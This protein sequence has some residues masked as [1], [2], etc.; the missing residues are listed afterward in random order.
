MTRGICTT[1]NR[2]KRSR[3]FDSKTKIKFH[4]R[5]GNTWCTPGIEVW[6]ADRHVL[7]FLRFAWI[8][9]ETNSDLEY[10]F[11]PRYD[12]CETRFVGTHQPVAGAEHPSRIENKTHIYTKRVHISMCERL[13][14]IAYLADTAYHTWSHVFECCFKAQSSKFE[15]LFSLKCGKRNVRASSFELSKMSPQVGLAVHYLNSIRS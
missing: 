7:F 8:R 6:S 12:P 2:F 4:S 14:P 11:R 5:T 13:T 9:K 15:C 3:I 10:G 1:N